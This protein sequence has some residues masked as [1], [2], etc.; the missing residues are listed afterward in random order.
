MIDFI[1]Q[2][3][4]YKKIS[5]AILLLFPL[6]VFSFVFVI[7][8]RSIWGLIFALIP[9]VLGIIILKY[10]SHNLFDKIAYYLFFIG[11]I[12]YSLFYLMNVSEGGSGAGFAMA[13]GSLGF[14]FWVFFGIWFI[15][16][17]MFIMIKIMEYISITK[18]IT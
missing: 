1:L 13:L 6:I 7:F 17:Y 16:S 9:L 10:F 3:G 2:R 5:E 14:I 8:S 4:R 11:S 15:I 12:L 18:G